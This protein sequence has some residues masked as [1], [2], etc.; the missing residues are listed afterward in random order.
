VHFHPSGDLREQPIRPSGTR[1][2]LAWHERVRVGGGA[3]ATAMGADNRAWTDGDTSLSLSHLIAGRG[4]GL[5]HMRSRTYGKT[6]GRVR[7][8]QYACEVSILTTLPQPTH[9]HS[10]QASREAGTICYERP[11]SG[12][13]IVLAT[14]AKWPE[15]ATDAIVV[16]REYSKPAQTFP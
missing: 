14:V 16:G 10:S 7:G 12:V 2:P 8:H 6:V 9:P 1:W 13:E 3:F 5:G 11:L 4:Q 15:P